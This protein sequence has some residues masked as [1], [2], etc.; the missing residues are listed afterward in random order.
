MELVIKINLDNAA[1][2]DEPCI[3]IARILSEYNRKIL[4]NDN[5]NSLPGKF[6]DIN[7][8]SVGKAEVF[9]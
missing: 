7:G 6:R 8:N 3:E 2:C 5:L 9:L 1:F 4:E